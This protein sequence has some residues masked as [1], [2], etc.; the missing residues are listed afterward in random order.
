V[1]KPLTYRISQHPTLIGLVPT[2]SDTKVQPL[3]ISSLFRR[4]VGQ[5]E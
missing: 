4:Q 1:G 3:V 5:C 2:I